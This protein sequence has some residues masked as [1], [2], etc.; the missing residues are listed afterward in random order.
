MAFGKQLQGCLYGIGRKLLDSRLQYPRNRLQNRPRPPKYVKAIRGKKTDRARF[1]VR[2]LYP[3][4]R[5]SPVS[6]FDALSEQTDQL[7]HRR[8]EPCS[9]LPDGFQYQI[10]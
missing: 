2:Q 5:D 3:S 7:F 1:G 10:G 9:K 4:G 8:K 6:G